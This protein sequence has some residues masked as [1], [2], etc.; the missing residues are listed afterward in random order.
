MKCRIRLHGFASG[1]LFKNKTRNNETKFQSIQTST[2]S[3][4]F[5]FFFLK[6]MDDGFFLFPSFWM[7]LFLLFFPE[8]EG[9]KCIFQNAPIHPLAAFARLYNHVWKLFNFGCFANVIQDS[10]RFQILGYT[11]RRSRCFWVDWV[12]QAKHLGG[13]R[14]KEDTPSYSAVITV[15]NSFG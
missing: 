9:G 15:A 5:S 6:I 7:F 1:D 12:V 11:T 8:G 3:F 13:K 14:Q 2:V 4:F 10:E